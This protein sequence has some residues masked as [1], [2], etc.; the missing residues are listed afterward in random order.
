MITFH[1]IPGFH[2]GISSDFNRWEYSDETGYG[3]RERF[4][5]NLYLLKLWVRFKWE[6][7]IPDPPWE[8]D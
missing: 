6:R 1:K 3:L 5:I 2:V 4:N 7:D 8:M